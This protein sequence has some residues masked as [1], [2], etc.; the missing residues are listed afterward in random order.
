MSSIPQQKHID[1]ISEYR[2][3][4]D[5]NAF[6][7]VFVSFFAMISPKGACNPEEKIPAIIANDEKTIKYTE[8][9]L[10]S[11]K[12]ATIDTIIIGERVIIMRDSW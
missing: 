3:S 12:L 11:L 7:R 1:K 5:E 2:N 4:K 9:T 6:F 10:A 8:N